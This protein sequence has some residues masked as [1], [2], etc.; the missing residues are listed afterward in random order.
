MNQHNR[1]SLPA[2]PVILVSCC[3]PKLS[4]AAPAADLYT[5]DLFKKARTYAEKRGRWF[6]LS[7]LHGLL[8]P[9][10]VIDPYDV[11][12]GKLSAAKRR[13]WGQK[14]RE[15][16]AET[17]LIGMPMISLAGEDYVK[18]LEQAGL[19]V[20]QPMKG[21]GIGER[22]QWLKMANG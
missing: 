10:A 20:A 18:P 19:S 8:T 12:L 5:S 6:I 1:G 15:Q 17:G 7:A 16:M 13:E 22:K 21:L 11:I 9:S 3:G 14:V 2:D 4:E